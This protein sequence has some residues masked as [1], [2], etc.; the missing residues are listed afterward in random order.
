MRRPALSLCLAAL[1]FAL[2]L[3]GCGP[4]PSDLID[5]LSGNADERERARQELLLA[6]DRAVGP[7]IDALDDPRHAGAR[8]DLV[9]VLAGLMNR[10]EADTIVQALGRHLVDDPD[11]DVRARI[12]HHLG[13]Q[14]RSDAVGPLLASLEDSAA[15]VRY[16]AIVALGRLESRLPA[17]EL[18]ALRD[19]AR[20][21]TEDADVRVREE[22]MMILASET[23]QALDKAGQA[24]LEGRIDA[25]E[26]LYVDAVQQAPYSKRALY[27]LGRFH[28]DNGDSTRAFELLRQHGMLL[29]VPRLSRPPVLDGS[30]DDPVWRTAAVAEDFHSFSSVHDAALSFRVPTRVY[31]GYTSEALY[32]GYHATDEHPDSLV[33]GRRDEVWWD[34]DVEFYF[35]ATFDHRTYCQVGINSVG[36]VG[37]LCF[38]GGLYQRTEWTAPVDV[39]AHVGEDAWFVEVRLPFGGEHVGTPAPGTLWGFNLIRVYRGLEYAQWTRT[40]GQNAHTPD[41]F[42]LLRFQ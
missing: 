33:V 24:V 35:D 23:S 19:A 17:D 34:D 32:L 5:D 7:L 26:S 25:A 15:E 42:G 20:R 29:D 28:L 2:A 11:A 36:R 38:D 40:Y 22:A 12:A 10:V 41:E 14:R 27:R 37:S 6:K 13:L 1:A 18:P 39:Q 8:L 30:L 31:L 16:E 21:T 3:S 9:E 4:T